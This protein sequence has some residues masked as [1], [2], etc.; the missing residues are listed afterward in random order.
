MKKNNRQS[1]KKYQKK[2]GI[3]NNKNINGRSW[4]KDQHKKA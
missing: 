3:K 1:R 4:K 2:R